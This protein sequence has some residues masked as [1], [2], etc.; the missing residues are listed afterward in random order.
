MIMV[1][2]RIAD[3]EGGYFQMEEGATKGWSRA[4]DESMIGIVEL[5]KGEEVWLP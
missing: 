2:C 4:G 1:C 5:P 3:V